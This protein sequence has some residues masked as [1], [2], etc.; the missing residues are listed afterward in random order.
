MIYN[1]KFIKELP[2][3]VKTLLSVSIVPISGAQSTA[4]VGRSRYRSSR[5]VELHSQGQ[6]SQK[7]QEKVAWEP[8]TN[9]MSRLGME[10]QSVW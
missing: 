4:G 7:P 1:M 2:E 9:T 3:L 10:V 8:H 5:G 6:D